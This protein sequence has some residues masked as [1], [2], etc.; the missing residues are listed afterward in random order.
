MSGR[1]VYQDVASNGGFGKMTIDLSGKSSGVYNVTIT[2]A[3][4]ST[5]K[6]VVLK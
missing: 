4:S 3:G 5:T 1:T 2:N 6:K